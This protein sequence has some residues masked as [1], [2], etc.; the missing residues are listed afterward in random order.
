MPS[1]RFLVT[2]LVFLLLVGSALVVLVS[3]GDGDQPMSTEGLAQFTDPEVQ[4]TR[5]GVIDAVQ[6]L[7][8]SGSDPCEV[9]A[10]APLGH[11]SYQDQYSTL[12]DL[13][14]DV[15]LVVVGRASGWT[16]ADVRPGTAASVVYAQIE[17]EEVLAGTVAG[18]SIDI[19]VGDRVIATGD[20]FAR[21]PLEIDSCASGRLLLFANR[22]YGSEQ[23]MLSSGGWVRLDAPGLETS[24]IMPVLEGFDDAEALLADVRA[25]AKTLQAQ[26]VPKGLLACQGKRSSRSFLPPAGCPGEQLDLRQAFE[27]SSVVEASVGTTDPGPSRLGVASVTLEADSAELAALLSALDFRVAL[28][29]LGP[30]PPDIIV[31][32]LEVNVGGQAPRSHRLAY[33]PR[34]GVVRL[35]DSQFVASPALVEAMKRYLAQ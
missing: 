22:L 8:D 34:E 5:Q 26:P 7:V 2:L 1:S 9:P 14:N 21:Q 32:T 33:S 18:S 23:Y 13:I 35:T 29:P 30:L 4:A 24:V 6:Q 15:D 11:L 25:S 10:T 19:T 20:V 27:L 28:E 16:M 17:I 3:V 31:A 12:A